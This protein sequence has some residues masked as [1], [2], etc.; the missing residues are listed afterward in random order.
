MTIVI[1]CYNEANRLNVE[2]FRKFA[3]AEPCIRF[4]F[5]NDGSTDET[6]RILHD[7]QQ[8]EPG[9]FSVHDLPNNMGKAQAVRQ[10]VLRALAD[11]C[12]YVGFWDADLATPLE[13]ISDFYEVLS[14]DPRLLMVTGARVRLLGR[15]IERRRSR[16]YLGR[17]FAT[18]TSLILSLPLYD[19]QCGAKLFRAHPVVRALFQQPFVTDWIFDVELFA[20]LI[21]LCRSDA[22]HSPQDLVYELPLQTW[23]DVAGSKL[24]PSDYLKAVFGLLA[25]YWKYLRPAATQ[26]LLLPTATSDNDPPIH[27]RA[28]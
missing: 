1:P 21:Q 6:K 27:R 15:T 13:A 4:L 24:K 25:V 26:P 23:C 8:S 3:T 17:L 28:A 2:A 11:P 22:R 5:V 9:R 19:T 16:H 14:G 7:L 18:C 20:R 12:D 10:G